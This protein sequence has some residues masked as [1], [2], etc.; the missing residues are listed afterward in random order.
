[1]LK[2]VENLWAVGVPFKPRWGAYSAPQT[3]ELVGGVAA[4]SP[5]TSSPFLAFGFSVLPPRAGSEAVRID[6][7]RFLAGCLLA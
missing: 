6:P 2:I 7:L 4:P 5:R 1:V 3:A